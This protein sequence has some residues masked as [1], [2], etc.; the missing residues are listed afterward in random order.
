[1][2]ALGD[3]RT[4]HPA[5]KAPWQGHP[6][7]EG[8]CALGGGDS[9]EALSRWRNSPFSHWMMLV[10]VY[11]R[12]VASKSLRHQ[13]LKPTRLLCPWDSPGKNTGGEKIPF[14]RAPSQP[15][16]GEGLLH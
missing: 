1:M 7:R 12:S 5:S 2:Q 15:R 8:P 10:C 4:H 3:P 16:E 14:S 11:A 13:G 6:S 9:L